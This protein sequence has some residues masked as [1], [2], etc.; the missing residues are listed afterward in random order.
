MSET[1][2]I[3]VAVNVPLS[4]EFDYLPPAG[5]PPPQPGCRV[6]V[7]FGHRRQT[8]VVTALAAMSPV[9]IFPDDPSISSVVRAVDASASSSIVC[10]NADAV[11]GVAVV[12]TAKVML[13][14]THSSQ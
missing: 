1:A 14:T 2:I 11:R 8:A 13:S 9:A 10:M 6:L 7:P 5:E 3:K 12:T 4:R